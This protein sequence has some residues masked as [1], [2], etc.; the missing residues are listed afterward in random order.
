MFTNTI[1]RAAYLRHTQI[2]KETPH[3]LLQ[4]LRLARTYI[5]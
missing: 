2:V 3:Q 1:V 5:H 4:T